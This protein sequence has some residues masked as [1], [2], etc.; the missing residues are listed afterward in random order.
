MWRLIVLF[1]FLAI[2]FQE[3]FAQPSDSRRG[4]QEPL[5]ISYCLQEIKG[6][7]RFH[8]KIINDQI[9]YDRRYVNYGGQGSKLSIDTTAIH[10][11]D[12]DSRG[13]TSYNLNWEENDG[14]L[15]FM[16]TN[17]KSSWDLRQGKD[18]VQIVLKDAY[19]PGCPEV[20]RYIVRLN[21]SQMLT[22]DPLTRDYY[23][24][25]RR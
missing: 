16:E 14:E 21:K 2:P 12:I 8:Y 17:T 22:V 10:T 9:Q 7:W 5:T 6:D 23:F 20:V 11:Y 3:S 4:V 19:Y 13:R 25:T 24:Y 15:K 1:A 18:G